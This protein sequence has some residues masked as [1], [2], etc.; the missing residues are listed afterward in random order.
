MPS[1]WT[2]KAMWKAVIYV[3]ILKA[4]SDIAAHYLWDRA[5]YSNVPA[6]LWM[7]PTEDETQSHNDF[8]FDKLPRDT[9]ISFILTPLNYWFQCWLERVLPGRARIAPSANVSS[10]K[11]LIE[12]TVEGDEELEEEMMR[13][14][15]ARGKVQRSTLSWVNTALKWLLIN[16]VAMEVFGLCISAFRGI[17]RRNSARVIWWELKT[18]CTPLCLLRDPTEAD[19]PLQSLWTTPLDHIFSL[20]P[21]TSLLSLII[22]PVQHR[23]TFMAAAELTFNVFL[24]AFANVLIPWLMTKEWALDILRNASAASRSA[25][26]DSTHVTVTWLEPTDGVSVD[27]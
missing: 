26:L 16:V 14:L 10:E 3:V 15:L 5:W 8:Y 20:A 6:E 19:P 24:G 11:P 22:I 17:W 21:T 27:L 25:A 9:I 4:A 18:V 2:S 23:L 12:K 1:T 7:E 13:R